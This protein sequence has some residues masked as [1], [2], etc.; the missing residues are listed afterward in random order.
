LYS[1]EA[2]DEIKHRRKKAARQEKR[3]AE[4]QPQAEALLR[5]HVSENGISELQAAIIEAQGLAGVAASL[6]AEVLVA[7]AAN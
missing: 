1:G 2:R 7:G 3:E 6:V 4:R 5:L